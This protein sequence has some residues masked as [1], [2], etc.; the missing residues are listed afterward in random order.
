MR[1]GV[2]TYKGGERRVLVRGGRRVMVRW[3]VAIKEGEGG[4]C[5][6]GE[7]RGGRRVMVRWGVAIK[8]GEEGA[9]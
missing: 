5:W 2:A 3:G 6:L 4:G 7:C 9:G 8:E 1:W